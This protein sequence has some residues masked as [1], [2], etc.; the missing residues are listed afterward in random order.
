MAVSKTLA[1]DHPAYITPVVF[2]GLTTAGAVGLSTKFCA[3]T[4]SQ[5][6]RV[7]LAAV[8]VSTSSTVPL[9]FSKSGTT[10]TTTTFT[11]G[12]ASAATSACEHVLATAIS[13]AQG[14][15][16]WVSHGTDGT[17]IAAAAIE[18]YPVGGASLACPDR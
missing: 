18:T 1:Y 5:L 6:R 12:I 15:Q 7:V 17:I 3:F 14:D 8:T 2:S 4:T 13:L 10:T 11:T 9:I 16:F